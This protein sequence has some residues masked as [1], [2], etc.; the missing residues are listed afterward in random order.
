MSTEVY[1]PHLTAAVQ[2]HLQQ[3]GAQELARLLAYFRQRGGP[4]L[5]LVEAELRER[6]KRHPLNYPPQ[7]A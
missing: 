4:G 3:Q 6:E 5:A 7:A 2:A 1:S